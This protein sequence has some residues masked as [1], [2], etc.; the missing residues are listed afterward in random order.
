MGRKLLLSVRCC[1]RKGYLWL[2]LLLNIDFFRAVLCYCKNLARIEVEGCVSCVI[3]LITTI[4][5]SVRMGILVGGT[6]G[7]GVG[8]CFWYSEILS[9][10]CSCVTILKN[11]LR[12]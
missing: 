3:T 6:L 7:D 8:D 4:G 1:D 12:T 2:L 9:T 11:T 10:C 5:G